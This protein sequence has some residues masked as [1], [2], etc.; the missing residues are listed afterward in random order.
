MGARG[1]RL[2]AVGVAVMLTASASAQESGGDSASVPASVSESVSGSV[3]ASVPVPVL[4]TPVQGTE[5]VRAR[6][7]ARLAAAVRRGLEAHGYHASLSQE[8]VGRALVACRTPECIAQALDAVGAAFAIVPAFWMRASGGREVTLTLVQRS[9]RSLNATGLVGDDLAGVTVGL[10]QGLLARRAVAAAATAAGTAAATATGSASAIGT[11]TG[12]RTGARRAG[13]GRPHAWKAGPIT[14]I[15]GGAAAIVAIG[16][17]AGV[18]SD[19][20]QLDTSAVAAWAAL[21]AAAIG[22]GIAWWVVGE[23]RRR[24]NGDLRGA[25]APELAL[26]P[27]KIDLRLRF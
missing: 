3:P 15:A 1:L 11:G 27:T 23:K 21:G 20:Q 16:V 6:D 18:K 17:G 2:G 25:L 9:G 13:R 24:K 4:L 14:L 26:H 22:G 8:L 19:D 12:T 7:G 5:S 10:V